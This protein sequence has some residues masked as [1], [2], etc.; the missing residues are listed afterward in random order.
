MI[1]YP[2]FHD[3]CRYGLSELTGKVAMNHKSKCKTD[4]L[5]FDHK[6]KQSV[7]NEEKAVSVYGR[8]DNLFELTGKVAMN[9]TSSCKT[10][11]L[12]LDHGMT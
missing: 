3:C 10:A 1:T 7:S 9:L 6:K 5:K 11:T 4:T 12:E 8:H 2:H